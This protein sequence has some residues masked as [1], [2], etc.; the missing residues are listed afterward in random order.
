MWGAKLSQAL[1]P[2]E[3]FSRQRTGH[4]QEKVPVI[5]KNNIM[6]SATHPNGIIIIFKARNMPVSRRR[7]DKGRYGRQRLSVSKC[8][9][10]IRDRK[11]F[12]FLIREFN[13]V[14]NYT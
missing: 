10:I 1:L 14:C 3:I 6:A 4:R 13:A 8:A 5:E 11:Q 9:Y 2:T 12:L 7:E